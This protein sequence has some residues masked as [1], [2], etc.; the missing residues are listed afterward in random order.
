MTQEQL[1]G[2]AP[3]RRPRVIRWLVLLVLLL[4][5]GVGACSWY[6]EHVV[7]ERVTPEQAA[8]AYVQMIVDGDFEAWDELNPPEPGWCYNAG[9]TMTL[10]EVSA[11]REQGPQLIELSV[12]PTYS[13]RMYVTDIRLDDQ[14]QTR[15]EFS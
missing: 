7:W 13:S 9:C 1:W 8:R 11:Q 10:T 3:A 15:V 2:G 12:R 14:G 4:V 5:I 6:R